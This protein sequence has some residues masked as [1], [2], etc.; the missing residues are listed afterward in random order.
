MF[1]KMFSCP[2]QTSFHGGNTGGKNFGNLGVTPA[3]LDEREKRAILGPQ[4]REGMAQGIEFLGVDGAGR[5]GDIFVLRSEGQEN[6][7]EFLATELINAGVAGQPEKPGLELRGGLEP[8]ECADHLDEH[9]LCK[10]FDIVTAPGHG[11]DEAGDP[12]LITDNELPLGGFVALLSAPHKI[13][14]RSR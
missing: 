10:I 2:M 13:D 9:L 8:I 3:F 1:P 5:L 12:V 11:V 7:A 4:L 14:Q 6:A